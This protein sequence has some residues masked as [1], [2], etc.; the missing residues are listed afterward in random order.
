VFLWT[1]PH[2][3]ALA[4]YKRDDYARAKIPMLPV[5]AGERATK[6]QMLLYTLL[7]I[8]VSLAPYF[9][10]IAGVFYLGA[11]AALSALFLLCCVRVMMTADHKPAKQM[12]AFSILYLFLIFA[13][14]IA[15]PI[16]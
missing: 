8:P 14:L 2:F 4:L 13:C 6:I 3:W 7:L 1:P 9:A 10:H 16:V 12:F 15:N 11:A 5:V